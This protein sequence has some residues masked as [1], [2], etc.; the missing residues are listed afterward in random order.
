MRHSIKKYFLDPDAGCYMAGFAFARLHKCI[1]VSSKLDFR[2]QCSL[3]RYSYKT[4]S[5]MSRKVLCQQL[6]DL[7]RETSD[8]KIW[9][10]ALRTI[11]ALQ[12][13]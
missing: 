3:R 4:E 12:A 1:S 10:K 5:A 7:Y 2:F 9:L 11:H 6:D 13:K 8:C